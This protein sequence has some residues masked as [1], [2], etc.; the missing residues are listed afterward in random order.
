MAT[1]STRVPG[2]DSPAAHW[3]RSS[4][5]A[6]CS[7]TPAFPHAFRRSTCCCAPR[8]AARPV[9]LRSSAVRVRGR[10]RSCARP[11]ARSFGRRHRV[12][13]HRPVRAGARRRRPARDR[14]PGSACDVVCLLGAHW[15]D[16]TLARMALFPRAAGSGVSPAGSC[17]RAHGRGDLRRVDARAREHRRPRRTRVVRVPGVLGTSTSSRNS[18]ASVR[19]APRRVRSNSIGA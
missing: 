1:Q 2:F 9:L 6:V 16:R 17:S 5:S 14:G 12:E 15:A 19:R 13:H 3:R 7:S 18:G 10:S 11:A 4:S 8:R